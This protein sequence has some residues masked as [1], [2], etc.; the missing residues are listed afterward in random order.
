MG[1][2]DVNTDN[3]ESPVY[4]EEPLSIR[5]K[6]IAV[7]AVVLSLAV[8]YAGLKDVTYKSQAETRRAVFACIGKLGLDGVQNPNWD[9]SHQVLMCAN[10]D[11]NQRIEAGEL[12]EAVPTATESTLD[13]V[14]EE[15]AEE[16]EESSSK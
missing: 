9:Q 13:T 11:I 7:V 1:K 4:Q 10:G 8:G 14:L 3:N 16:A 6:V 5:T 15:M 12:F 2:V